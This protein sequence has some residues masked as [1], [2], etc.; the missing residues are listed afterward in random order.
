[1]GFMAPDRQDRQ[2]GHW[3]TTYAA[4]PAMYGGAPSAPAV[5]AAEVF[6]NAGVHNVLE[7]GRDALFFAQQA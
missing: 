4:H 6:R 2:R 3:D 7:L 5:Y 1:M